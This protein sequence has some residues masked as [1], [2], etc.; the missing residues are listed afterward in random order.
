MPTKRASVFSFLKEEL[1]LRNLVAYALVFLTCFI[2]AK[3]GQYLFYEQ[4][5]SPAL[6][7]APFG[8][9]LGAILVGGY[10]M[11]LPIALAELL[12]VTSAGI[13]PLPVVIAATVGQTLQPLIGAWVMRK[14]EFDNGLGRIRDAFVLIGIAFIA[15]A[16]SPSFS[17]L[18]QV[19]THTLNASLEVTWVRNWAGGILS[20]LILTPLITVWL[21]LRPFKLPRVQ[22]LETMIALC[23][24]ATVT[25]LLGWTEYGASYGLTGIYVLLAILVWISIRMEPRVM[26]LALL[27][28]AVLGM[29][30]S[31]YLHSATPLN[32]Q[33]FSQE[34]FIEFLAV[35][36]IV[37]E[38]L[39][40]ERRRARIALEKNVVQL[41][42]AIEK[43]ANE[44]V[45]KNQFIAT[46]AHELR[47]PLAP[48]VSALDL[49]TLQQP[50]QEALQTIEGA[51]REL[52][53]M[54][55]L[56][57]DI[58]DVARI[59][60]TRFKLQKEVIDVRSLLER[61]VESTRVFLRNRNHTL[62]VSLPEDNVLVE[63][64]PVRLQQIV[65]NLL[66]NA[67][68]YTPPGGQIELSC[69][70][71]GVMAKIQVRDN[72]IGIP[73][74][75][76]EEVFEPFR[77]I[78]PTTQ[79]GTGL[80]I[81]LWLTKQLVEMH[82]GLIVAESEGLEQGSCFTISLPLKE[83]PLLATTSAIQISSILRPMKVLVVDDNEAAAHAMQ[84]LLQLKGHEPKVAYDGKAAI[85]SAAE[86]TP[87]VILL[88]IGLPDMSG[89]DVA[90]KL[91]AA[92]VNATLIALTG[93]G[94]DEDKEQAKVA[95]FDYHLTKPVGIADIEGILSQLKV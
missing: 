3:F 53:V 87:Q 16:I 26:T 91:L 22:T 95:G 40:E 11:W 74:E 17:T 8:I 65:V 4:H 34:L 23:L 70:K 10:R 25:I 49:L 62:K 82:D 73:Q 6:I 77:Q 84:R 7:W 75:S 19:A 58:L 50:T 55:R 27:L 72:G 68:K 32:Q 80:G 39:V 59:S 76:L 93:Y 38:G 28:L 83:T 30:G 29:G 47:N 21:P 88:D 78:R 52:N 71:E 35:I 44:D 64:D 92:G 81:G 57:D 60:Q 67:G 36:F 2:T 66:N 14:F 45:A 20:I 63:V 90:R 56:L 43:I 37:F 69:Q 5:T 85:T 42:R 51:Q 1:R 24:L 31:F 54:R 94:Q 86:F 15:A 18:A 13:S 61:A 12:A 41:E 89:Y 9:A 46:L 79:I 33:L 48:V